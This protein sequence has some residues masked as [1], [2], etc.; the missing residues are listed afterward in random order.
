MTTV[1]S[2]VIIP[3]TPA[4]TEPGVPMPIKPGSAITAAGLANAEKTSIQAEAV[5]NLGGK[6]GGR[7]R[8]VKKGKVASLARV[9]RMMLL[10]GA[11]VP[12]GQI[13]VRHV[14]NMVSSG[15]VDAKAMYA[16]LLA[17]QNQL[18]ADAQFDGLGQASPQQVAPLQAQ[19][20][21]RHR[22]KKTRKH[23]NGRSKHAGVRKSR[24]A[25]HRSRRV[26][27]RRA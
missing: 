5:K 4:I 21:R 8:V 2:G 12:A 17:T 19:G 15:S 20:G 11:G 3:A 13:E 16:G 7:R 27:S 22:K 9:R 26:R 1:N 24:R 10:G 25:T 23:H 14:P 6:I 18:A